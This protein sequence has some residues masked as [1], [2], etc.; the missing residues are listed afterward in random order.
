MKKKFTFKESF[1]SDLA[2]SVVVFLVALPLCLGI[3]VVSGAP[4]MSGLIA[5]IVGGV[6]V[7]AFSG[8][9]LGV[10][11][12]AAG[13]A[14]I[15][16]LAI[17]NFTTGEDAA[18]LGMG[19]FFAAV[20]L[21]G[22]IQ[23]GMGFL[24]AGIIAY[25]FPVSV[26]RGMLSGIGIV[27]ILKEIPHAFG[28]DKDAFGDFGFF[29]KDGHNTIS[30]IWYTLLD[31]VPGAV[32]LTLVSLGIL[33]LWERPFMN[34]LKLT[35]IIKGPLV[36][37]ALGIIATLGFEGSYFELTKEHLVSVPIINSVD[38]LSQNIQLADFTRIFNLDVLILAFTIALVASLET[39]LCV[40]ATDKLDPY[41]RITPT[42]RELKAQGIGNVVSGLIGGLPITQVIVRSSANIQSGGKTKISAIVH[43]FLL[44]VAVLMLP[45]VINLIP[46]AS[47]AA[48]LFVV[49][50][51]LAKPSL[52]KEMFQ[53]GWI[54]FLPF[55][56]TI[57]GIVFTNLL[58]GIALGLAVAIAQIL[59]NN[60]RRPYLFDQ[61]TDDDSVYR[62]EL[63]E[64]VTFIN[65]ANI[66]K[67]LDSIPSGSKVIIDASK[68]SFIHP[69]VI[70]IF[71]DFE[72]NATH[73]NVEVDCVGFEHY[74]TKFNENTYK[75]FE[76]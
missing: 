7:G 56:I 23:I 8:S 33:I 46:Y 44:L 39:L 45:K 68:S 76:A 13:L 3:A 11:G 32:L 4:A 14:A 37:V 47:L 34:K 49:G 6:I 69:D 43:G 50:Y 5:G 25:Y 15:V 70:E 38:S 19:A 72:T 67:T 36:V 75:E 54:Q 61:Q 28:Y 60:Y 64:Q 35:K 27:I 9:S 1:S 65:K 24:K 66:Q 42:N 55:I 48:I 58:V 2:A 10:S 52:F 22:F 62:F 63:T 41:K 40:E 73:N 12:P 18:I 71:E 16:F 29:Q 17:E 57:L 53:K 20:V 30:E 59:I 74:H 31:F 26:I 51:K 21:A